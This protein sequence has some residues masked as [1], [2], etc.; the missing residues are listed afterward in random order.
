M[1]C[2]YAFIDVE[3]GMN[4]HKIHDIGALRYNGAVYH[5]CSKDELTHFLQGMKFVC[6]HNII[7][8]DA[9]YLF[10]DGECQWTL[11]D[12]LY[13]SPLLFPERP[14]HRL[15]KDDKLISEQMN[16]PVNDCEKARDLLMDEMTAWQAWDDRKRRIFSALLHGKPEF[17]GF[18]QMVEAETGDANLPALIRSEYE[19]RICQ[20]A[21]VDVLVGMYP[22]E[23]AYALSLIDTTD[24]RSVTPGWVLYNYPGVEY[25]MGVLRQKHCNEPDCEYCKRMLDVHHN[26]KAFFGYDEFRRYEG[27]PLQERAAR[28][29]VEG[30]SLLAIFPT[31]GGKS[32]TFQLPALMAGRAVHGLTVVISPLLSLMK[33]QVDNLAKNGITDAVTINGLLDKLL[34]TLPQ[35]VHIIATG[36]MAKDIVPLCRHQ[37]QHD[38]FLLLKGLFKA[39]HQS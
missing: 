5:G 11:V 13:F 16:N 1:N 36:G 26:L 27:E 28:A 9:K 4:D 24:E 35:P 17:Q 33:D 38:K 7:H 19:G 10:P 20:H 14:Y 22:V 34:A 3:V 23:L 18:L 30:R 15:L 6:G 8:H 25:V 32:L 37:M 2:Q 39:T 12:T 29:A 31:G 21:D